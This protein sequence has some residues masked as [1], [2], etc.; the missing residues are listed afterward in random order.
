MGAFIQSY[1]CADTHPAGLQQVAEDTEDTA[2][3]RPVVRGTVLAAALV[4]TCPYHRHQ[5]PRKEEAPT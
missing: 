3:D 5:C 1:A 2:E 4:G